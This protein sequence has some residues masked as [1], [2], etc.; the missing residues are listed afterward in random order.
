M[1]L[2]LAALESIIV[3]KSLRL[4]GIAMG[5]YRGGWVGGG[6]GALC[7]QSSLDPRM[8]EDYACVCVL[9]FSVCLFV[10]LSV[11]LSACLSI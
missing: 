4:R 6:G 3:E 5:L 1:A 2:A 7:P 8:H 9:N 11:C 10:C